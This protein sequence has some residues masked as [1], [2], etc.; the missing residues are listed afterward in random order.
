MV[1][2][3]A[4]E[5][6]LRVKICGITRPED[7]QAAAA[8]GTDAV[9][10]ICVAASPRYLPV[11][12]ARAVLAALPPL[13][14]PVGVFMDATVPAI[15][16]TAAALGLRT[17]QLHGNEPPECVAALRPLCVVKALAVRGESIYAELSRWTAAGVAGLLLDKPRT[18]RASDPEPMPWE[19]LAPRAIQRACGPVAPILL[20][21]GLTSYNV[22]E[23]VRIVQPYGVDV[24]SG[25]ERGTGVKD[26]DLIKT[27]VSEARRAAD[28]MAEGPDDVIPW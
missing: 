27:F 4:G 25:V 20:A 26:P 3:T 15:L 1:A 19:L 12:K 10:L 7:G 16:Q 24:S 11:D 23:A 28:G 13:V 18:A 5:E 6:M 17:V 8:A 9:G 22:A 14:T 2:Y 21:G